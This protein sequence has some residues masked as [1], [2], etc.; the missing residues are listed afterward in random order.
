GALN[1]VI[2]SVLFIVSVLT[3]SSLTIISPG[4]TKVVQ[5]FGRYLGTI[6]RT[7]LLI[8]TPFTSKRKVSVK[9]HNFETNELKVNDADGNPVMIAAIMVWQVEDTA[10]SVIAVED[11]EEFVAVQ[12]ESALRHVA[13]TYPD[14]NTNT[15]GASLRGSAEKVAADLSVEV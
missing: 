11:C 5:F 14:D 6:R 10:K 7:G 3:F 8:T 2:A 1:M 12:P 9:V 13:S 4:D 15:D